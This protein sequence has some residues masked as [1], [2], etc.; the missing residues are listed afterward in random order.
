MPNLAAITGSLEAE[1]E[2][3]CAP[4]GPSAASLVH[5]LRRRL[6]A[7][8]DGFAWPL[9][10]SDYLELA[11]P[12]WTRRTLRARVDDV[13]W[14]TRDT[15]TLTLRPG[16]GWRAHRAG[17]F[18]VVGVTLDGR[19]HVRPFSI[20]SAP[21]RPDGRITITVRAVPGGRVSTHLVHGLTPGTHLEL[22]LP[23]GEFVLPDAPG[24]PPLFVTAG[25]GI[26][27]VMSMLRGFAA[28]G[29]VPDVVHLHWVPRAGD[30]IFGDELA[31]L[32]HA[33]PRYRLHVLTTREGPTS[34]RRLSA[35]AIEELCPDWRQREAWACGPENLLAEMERQWSTAGLE[36]RL[37]VERFR[38]RVAAAPADAR[39][40]RVRFTRSGLTVEADGATTLLHAA[41]HA[42]LR[43][44]H[45]CRM[46]I[47]YSCTARLRSG[48]VRDVRNG[49][50]VEH[51]GAAI[52][53][54]I[55]AASGD[56]EVEV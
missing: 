1:L 33:H 15:R 4:A 28:R 21:E 32:A 3:R 13:A 29:A 31:R 18:V 8:A 24:A 26:T 54:C 20:S 48:C 16:R 12:L 35:A 45:G 46:G 22:S 34:R 7:L 17:Q 40:G 19:R 50:R 6:A 2:P 38:P 44:A 42:G 36:G 41:E 37:H 10:L 47:C 49:R 14:E 27:P 30:V 23:Q 43:P 53:L 11:N 51:P 52:Q 25:S 5:A 39:G 55:S 56:V 9:R